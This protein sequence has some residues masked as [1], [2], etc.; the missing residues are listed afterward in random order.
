VF[1]AIMAGVVLNVG[2][3]MQKKAVNKMVATKQKSLKQAPSIQAT[4]EKYKFCVSLCS[5]DILMV[6][7]C[8]V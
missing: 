1:V 4:E 5:G 2:S 8:Q 7:H 3:L 6:K